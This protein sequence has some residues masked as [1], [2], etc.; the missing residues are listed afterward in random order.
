MEALNV[1]LRT[2]MYTLACR[3]QGLNPPC[4]LGKYALKMKTTMMKMLKMLVMM[5]MTSV[6]FDDGEH[7]DD[8]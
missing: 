2:S 8:G 3:R 5:M 1:M 6:D 7:D 4:S